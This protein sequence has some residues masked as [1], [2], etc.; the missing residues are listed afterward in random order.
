MLCAVDGFQW[1]AKILA[2]AG[3]Y[4]DEHERVIVSAYNV[5]FAATASTEIAK[6]NFITA[7]LQEPA[8]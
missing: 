7:T 2:R 5:D 8:R 6:Q 3:F 4:F 1:T